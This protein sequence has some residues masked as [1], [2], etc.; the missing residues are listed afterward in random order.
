MGVET[1]GYEKLIEPYSEP[2]EG[3][4]RAN[5]RT[6]AGQRLWLSQRGFPDPIVAEA[7]RLVYSELAAGREFTKREEDDRP[8]GYWLDRHILDTCRRLMLESHAGGLDA[9]RD[10]VKVIAS[11]ARS[12]LTAA[13]WKGI[14][15]GAGVA[16]T[17]SLVA[18]YFLWR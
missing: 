13:F 6:A 12:A 4:T 3:A 8:A 18:G 9:A 7:M 17:L 5:K 16:S 15:L 11:F 2:S 1:L 14:A 10:D